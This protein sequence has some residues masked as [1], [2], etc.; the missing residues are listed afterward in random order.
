MDKKR[1][2]ELLELYKDNL[3]NDIIPFW[4]KY[5]VDRQCGGYHHYLDR[6]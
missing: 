6:D 5:S 1:K 3:F 4:T 2:K